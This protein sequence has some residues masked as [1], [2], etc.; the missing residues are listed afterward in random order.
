[1]SWNLLQF[2]KVGR[3][4]VQ[5]TGAP[6][7]RSVWVGGLLLVMIITFNVLQ[8]KIS[9]SLVAPSFDTASGTEWQ[10]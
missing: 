1:M 7:N 8:P 4:S 10:E 9:L 5:W 3:G 2:L 6:P